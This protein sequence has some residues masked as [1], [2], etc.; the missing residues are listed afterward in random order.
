MKFTKIN[1]PTETELFIKQIKG[2]ILSGELKPGE[3]L[4]S[5]RKLCE[6]LNVSRN[7]INSGLKELQR[8]HFIKIKP[9]Y[10]AFVTDFRKDGNLETLNA[11]LNYYDGHYH[12]SLLKS[13]Y[14]TRYQI[15]TDI[16]RLACQNNDL[17]NLKNAEAT[18]NSL[19]PTQSAK[20][21]AQISFQVLHLISLASGNF[22][23]PL[24]VNTFEP[25][26]LT[27]G[28]WICSDVKTEDIFQKN[29]TLLQAIKEKDNKKAI[30]LN[31]QKIAWSF[32]ILTE[33]IRK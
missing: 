24:M 27:L 17:A 1:V 23:Y 14:D 18:I 7:V 4:P 21:K 13:L 2:A 6:E 15:E 20:E 12:I 32:D 9:R 10:G 31:N 30:N 11:L 33:S 5:E 8:L 19:N 25:L 3:K 16:I 26:Y 28:E 29:L 22:V